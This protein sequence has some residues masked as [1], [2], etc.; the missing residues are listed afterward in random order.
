M[1][2]PC[3]ERVFLR[4]FLGM[5]EMEKETIVPNIERNIRLMH[6]LLLLRWH[7]GAE[8]ELLQVTPATADLGQHYLERL[9]R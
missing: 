8:P 5:S 3:A 4:Q 7:A 9:Q 6:G 1:H 2:S